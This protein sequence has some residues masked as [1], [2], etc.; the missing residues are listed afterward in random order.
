MSATKEHYHDEIEAGTRMYNIIELD[1]LDKEQLLELARKKGCENI[2]VSGCRQI[3]IYDIL[4]K[5]AE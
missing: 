3:I 1:K 4:K 2:A 5:Q